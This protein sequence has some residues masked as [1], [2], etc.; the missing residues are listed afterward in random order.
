MALPNLG[1]GRKGRVKSAE[2][3]AIPARSPREQ[4]AFTHLTNRLK[5]TIIFVYASAIRHGLWFASFFTDGSPLNTLLIL[6]FFEGGSG[7][8][9]VNKGF[10]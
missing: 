1:P 6:K 3:G 9:F 8:T 10:P 4:S 5:M 7:E 2:I